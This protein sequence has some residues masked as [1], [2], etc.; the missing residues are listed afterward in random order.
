MGGAQDLGEVGLMREADWKGK[1]RA[2]GGAE[3][4]DGMSLWEG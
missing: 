4:D 1:A 2:R 3:D